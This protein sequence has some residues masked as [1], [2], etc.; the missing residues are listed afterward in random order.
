VQHIFIGDT[1][2]SG[3]VCDVVHTQTSYLAKTYFAR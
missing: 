1:V 3:A 2:P